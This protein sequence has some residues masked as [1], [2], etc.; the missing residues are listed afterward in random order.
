MT[1]KYTTYAEASLAAQRLKVKSKR[2]YNRSYQ[3]DPKLPCAPYQVYRKGWVDWYDFLGKK[4]PE[5]FYITYA[6]ASKAAQRLKLESYLEYSKGYQQDK[7]LP[8]CPDSIYGEGWV[9]WYDFLGTKRPGKKFYPSYAEASKAARRLKSKSQSEYN[10]SY[11]QDPKL[12]RNPYITYK[13]DWVDWYEFLGKKRRYATYA[14]ASRAAKRLKFKSES[15]YNTGYQQDPRLRRSPYEAYKE[16]WV[17]WYDFLGKKR[18]EEFYITYAEASKAAQRLKLESYPEYSKGYQQDPKLP[19][20]PY[21]FYRK[22][23]VDWYDFLG[24]KRPEEFYITYAEASKAA[25][26]LGLKSHSE[27]VKGYQQDSRLPS[28]PERT[29][30]EDWLNWRLFLGQDYF[31][32]ALL[33]VYPKIWEA[34]QRYVAG[35]TNQTAKFS[36]LKALLK[37]YV[38]KQKLIDDAGA[39]LSKDI[40][41][42]EQIYMDF[43]HA[44]GETMKKL[45]HNICTNFFDWLL[46]EYCSEEDDDGELVVL[47]GYRNPLRTVLRGL[48]DQLPSNRPT[49]S[50]KPPLPMDIIVRGRN[51]LIPAGTKMFR[52]I[53]QLHP[54]LD[55]CWF[56]IDPSLVDK[57]DPNC[58][59]R[60]IKKDRKKKNGGRYSE[61]AYELWSPVKLL[62]N[63]VL[64]SMPLRGQQICWLDSGEADEFIP[65]WRDGTVEWVK[66]TSHLAT[67]KRQQ[68]FIRKGQNKGELS[69]YISTNKTGRKLGGYHVPHM[70]GGLEYWIIQLRD[71]QSKYNPLEELTPWTKIKLR[72]RTNKD[73]LKRRGKQAFLFRDPASNVCEEKISP[74]MTTTAFARTLPALLFHIQLPGEDLAEQI[75]KA[76]SVEY[77]SQFTPHSLRVSL[78]TAYIV[79][80]RA[81]IAVI[82][83]LVG[84]SSLVMTI[85]YTRVGETKMRMEL[86]AAEKRALEEGSDRLQD[87]ILQKKIAEARPELIAT[88]WRKMEECL[89][90]DWPSAAYQFM[91]IGICPMSGAKCDEGGEALVE[92]KAEVHYA[93]VPSG[94]LGTRNCPRCRFFITGPAFLGGLTAVANEII[95]EINVIR[96]EYH[97]LEEKREALDDERYDAESKGKSFD[98][99]KEL[100]KVTAAYEERAK[101]LDMLACDLQYLWKLITQSSELLRKTETD[102]HQLIVSTDYVEMGMHLEEQKTDF[103]LLAEVCANA[104]IYESASASR[105]QPLLREML[106]K[107]ADTN[108]IAPAMF[109]LTK[110]QQLKAANQVVQLIMKATRNDWRLADQLVSGQI[111][112]EDLAEPLRLNDIRNEIESVMSGSLKFPLSIESQND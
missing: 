9:N 27:Y 40:P 38:S 6:E 106:D 79:D 53:Y 51:I 35:G 55:E 76:K 45:R 109:R 103:R 39:M 31:D 18:P 71:W 56:E 15:E 47:P 33:E 16:D 89:S 61:E 36:H 72:Q 66:N 97:E 46:Y 99:N 74:M 85:Y 65:V 25:Q 100:K 26:Q 96:G 11:Q 83:K 94:Y 107:L 105:A 98:G 60:I 64:L 57:N 17:D 44:T 13:E 102:K 92:R 23:W 2:E 63:Y 77:K 22:D 87:L 42:K 19:C 43:V 82:S 62:A 21:K 14:E 73:I 111:L 81:P 86:D 93:P 80:G 1:T 90:P 54:F 95:L 10:T 75:K 12:P 3:Q 78:I 5:E 48:L 88:D 29:F 104:E 91:S 32:P 84:H 67:P 58:I 50:N 8:A 68:G 59:Y 112:L 52:E 49:E 24:K 4:R 108:G 34:I 70:P 37:E 110:G 30:S 20:A 41:F 7:R 101:K 69:S 28:K